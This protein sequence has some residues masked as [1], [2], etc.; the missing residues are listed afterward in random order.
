MIATRICKAPTGWFSKACSTAENDVSA[1][2][3]VPLA[4]VLL[5]V[6]VGAAFR[7]FP[8][9]YQMRKACDGDTQHINRPPCCGQRRSARTPVSCLIASAGFLTNVSLASRFGESVLTGRR[10]I[11]IEIRCL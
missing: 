4:A 3:A 5:L 6:H 10:R 9:E 11:S 7:R 1:I 2:V 8:V